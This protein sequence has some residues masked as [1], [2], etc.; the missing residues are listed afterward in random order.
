MIK[1][2]LAALVSVF[3]SF[4]ATASTTISTSSVSGTWTIAGSPYIVQ[5]SIAVA[6]GSTLTI[7]PGVEVRFAGPYQMD[8]TGSLIA[9]GDAQHPITFRADDTTGWYNDSQSSGGWHGIH[10]LAYSSSTADVSAFSH[11]IVMDCKHGSYG[12]LYGIETFGVYRKLR[13]SNSEFYH[14]Q[15]LANMSNGEVIIMNTYGLSSAIEMDSCDVHDNLTRVNTIDASDY[16]GTSTWI[17]H[18]HIHHNGGQGAALWGRWC[19]LVFEDNEVDHNSSIY[20]MSAIRI[21]G[22]HATIRRNVIHHNIS[23]TNAPVTCWWGFVDIDNN[24]ICNN[25]HTS[26]FCGATQG[27]GGIHVLHND[28]SVA[29]STS[30][31]IRNNV[32]ANNYTPFYGG[33]IKV[34]A[35]KVLIA[36]NDIINNKSAYGGSGVFILDASSN[37]TVVNNIFHGNSNT[38]T[39][40]DISATHQVMN[41]SGATLHYDYNW[42]DFNVSASIYGM[43]A[44]IAGDTSHNTSGTAPGLISCTAGPDYTEDALSTN[45]GLTAS[46]GCINTGDATD[47]DPTISD[48]AGNT[49]QWGMIDKGAYEYGAPAGIGNVSAAQLSIYPNPAT[50]AL[51]VLI[52]DQNGTISLRDIQGRTLLVQE[53]NALEETVSLNNIPAGLYIIYWQNKDHSAMAKVV[54]R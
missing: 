12:N 54:V 48:Y 46:S 15:S 43:S 25:S 44:G 24:R 41:F 7:E 50:G 29:D 36:N 49:R 34:Y 2:Y 13:F 38:T 6:A 1:N 23:E 28:G 4:A 40:T 11:C 5:T 21:S 22:A 52:P 53:V 18:S 31:R 33:A 9:V 32:I 39:G 35:T 42:S 37:V 47:A 20:D 3:G 45:F 51:T 30:Y 17:H 16:G 19:N 27:G 10:Y 8:V 26:G 14:N